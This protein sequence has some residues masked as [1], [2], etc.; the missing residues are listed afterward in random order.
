M[1]KSRRIATLALG[2]ACLLALTACED[3]PKDR[4]YGSVEEC[5]ADGRD[6]SSCRQAFDEA[7]LAHQKD[8][9]RFTAQ[10]TCEETHGAGNCVPAQGGGG[11]FMPALTGFMMGRMMGGGQMAGATPVYRDRYGYSYAGGRPIPDLKP[12]AGSM[13]SAGKASTVQRGG[14]GSSGRSFSASS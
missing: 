14:F 8:A 4:V 12:A 13:S 9:P 5:V 7:G 11:W 2:G 3:K 1:R 6:E 10:G